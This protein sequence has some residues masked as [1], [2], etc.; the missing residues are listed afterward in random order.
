L[1]GNKHST[2]PK[3]VKRKIGHRPIMQLIGTQLAVVRLIAV[4]GLSAFVFKKSEA[5]DSRMND[6]QVF[7]TILGGT[8]FAVLGGV[9]LFLPF[10]LL[11]LTEAT[12]VLECFGFCFPSCPG[13]WAS[14]CLLGGFANA[15]GT[16]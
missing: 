5:G 4:Q 10:G 6:K 12:T 14:S 8:I 7:L 11:Q 3:I 15:T 9:L 13:L 16:M 2:F 1:Y